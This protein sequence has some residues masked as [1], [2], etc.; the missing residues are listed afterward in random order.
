MD[1]KRLIIIYLIPYNILLYWYIRKYI[2]IMGHKYEKI[3]Y[4]IYFLVLKL[5]GLGSTI[6]SLFFLSKKIKIKKF[7]DK[8]NGNLILVS[9]S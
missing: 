3:N 5:K 9:I 2:I 7:K 1:I 6:F 8:K 4:Y